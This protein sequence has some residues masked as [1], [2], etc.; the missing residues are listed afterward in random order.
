MNELMRE[1]APITA[2]AWGE[3]EEEAKRTLTT[4]LAARKKER[5]ARKD[6]KAR[7]ATRPSTL[8]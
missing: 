3:I 4:Y 6:Q 2:A 1:L 8:E 7:A 5:A